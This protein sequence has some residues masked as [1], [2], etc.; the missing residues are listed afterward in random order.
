MDRAVRHLDRIM[1][2][3]TCGARESLEFIPESTLQHTSSRAT[4]IIHL[5]Q[6]RLGVPLFESR[7]SVH[8]NEAGAVIL[9][10][11]NNVPR[12]GLPEIRPRVTASEALLATV[13]HFKEHFDYADYDLPRSKQPRF[14]MSR[15]EVMAVPQS[16]RHDTVLRKRPFRHVVAAH[17]TLLFRGDDIRLGWTLQVSLPDRL[18]TFE[19][20][21]GAD[22]DHGEE[23]LFCSRITKDVQ[24]QGRIYT[25]DPDTPRKTVSFPVAPDAYPRIR[26][27]GLPAAFPRPWVKGRR[28]VGNNVEARARRTL[29]GS[30]LSDGTIS[31]APSG[32]QDRG[33]VQA[34]Y[35]C[36]YLHDFFYLLGFRERERNFQDKN[37]GMGGKP[38]DE[39][40]V[41]IDNKRGA[42][43]DPKPEGHSCA[44]YLGN[45]GGRRTSLDSSVVI[46]E[47]VHGL[48]SRLVLGEHLWL[49]EK[50]QSLEAR[51]IDE[52]YCDYFAMSIEHYQRLS[53]NA[54]AKRR[55]IFAR[56]SAK[57]S[58]VPVRRHPYG[59]GFSL[60]HG[61]VL[62]G[63]VADQY[64]AGQVWAE[65]L[66]RMNEKIGAT[67]GEA[68]LGHEIGWQT[69]VNSLK[70]I[71]NPEVD[72]IE[73]A[74]SCL[75]ALDALVDLPISATGQPLL[76]AASHDAARLATESAFK[77]LG[78]D[79]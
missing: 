44:M 63:G 34:F 73:G 37:F 27:E 1:P 56:Y 5:Q 71:T 31:F 38:G 20:V 55:T 42:V 7:R 2:L 62:N 35:L 53:R 76:P 75:A 25:W 23:I 52:G 70:L 74:R 50:Q 13:R 47:Y 22:E 58:S 24:K 12:T 29:K 59:P 54:A 61:D 10:G 40:I 79:V 45:V 69:V 49:S 9:V 15:P 17:L 16:P 28:T 78:I 41:R 21:V 51:A 18:P 77:E 11:G 6:A 57:N 32:A 14:N 30:R 36:N 46:H 26:P 68:M 66:L 39:L 65:A 43:F 33:V 60:R 19:L 72:F 8:F 48:T 3:L 4:Q 64:D 67:L